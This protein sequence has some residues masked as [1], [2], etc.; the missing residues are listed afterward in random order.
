MYMGE[1][2]VEQKDI[3]TFLKAT[4]ELGVAG[5][6]D[7]AKEG[8]TGSYVSAKVN[9]KPIEERHKVKRSKKRSRLHDLTNNLS[10]AKK[11]KTDKKQHCDESTNKTEKLPTA[12]E[13]EKNKGHEE[14]VSNFQTEGEKVEVNSNA[15]EPVFV[16]K[17]ALTPN[18]LNSDKVSDTSTRASIDDRNDRNDDLTITI[19][20]RKKPS[21]EVVNCSSDRS[22][23][24]LS[25]PKHQAASPTNITPSKANIG[26][27]PSPST[28]TVMTNLPQDRAKLRDIWDTLV[29]PEEVE[30]ESGYCCL[31]CDKTFKGK[32]AKSNAWSHVDHNHTNHI[33]HKCHICDFTG[34]S[35]DAVS[36]HISKNHRKE[37]KKDQEK[38]EDEES[39][40]DMIVL[41]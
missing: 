41:D 28:K 15:E 18:K 8:F 29:A 9:E 23:E 38:I 31:C 2:K 20:P 34:K 16:F 40:E 36:R 32:S 39:E 37:P 6:S 12:F 27:I 26:T 1:T 21:E 7:A 35:N 10:K 22:S 13:D 19:S 5:L 4:E 30:G 14:S 3:S 33:E 17:K 24:K 25:P 11:D